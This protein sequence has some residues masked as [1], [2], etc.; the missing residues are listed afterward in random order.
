MVCMKYK[1][2]M[3]YLQAFILEVIRYC[4]IASS[5]H[6]CTSQDTEMRG[7]FIPKDTVVCSLI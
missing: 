3:H 5:A 6:K 7:Y 2:E 4:C 1:P